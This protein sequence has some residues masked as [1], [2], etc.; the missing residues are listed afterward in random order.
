MV[1]PPGLRTAMHFYE[2]LDYRF[3]SQ[4]A[5]Y[6]DQREAAVVMAKTLFA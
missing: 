1:S 2:S 6:Y 3:V 5:G 4:V